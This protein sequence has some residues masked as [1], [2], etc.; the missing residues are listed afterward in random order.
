MYKL[1]RNSASHGS[2]VVTFY[3]KN[4]GFVCTICLSLINWPL[5]RGY[6]LSWDKFSGYYCCREAN[7]VEEWALVEV[8]LNKMT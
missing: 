3:N 6:H 1:K 7:I 5:S 2:S 8:L 4:W